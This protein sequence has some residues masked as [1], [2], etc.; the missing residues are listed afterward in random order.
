MPCPVYE[1]SKCV[2]LVDDV[3]QYTFCPKIGR[4]HKKIINKSSEMKK[5]KLYNDHERTLRHATLV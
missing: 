3:K 5:K 2:A 4:P 1:P